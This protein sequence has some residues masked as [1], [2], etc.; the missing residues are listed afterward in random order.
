[1]RF[2]RAKPTLFS[3]FVALPDWIY[4]ALVKILH[5]TLCILKKNRL[6]EQT[7]GAIAYLVGQTYY[8]IDKYSNGDAA[9]EASGWVHG[10]PPRPVL[11]TLSVDYKD[12]RGH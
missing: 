2:L 4:K 10:A 3:L 5:K 7:I 12:E 1:M 6:G 9:G 11:L 8:S